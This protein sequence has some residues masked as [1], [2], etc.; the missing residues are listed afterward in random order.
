MK[1]KIKNIVISQTDRTNLSINIDFQNPMELEKIFDKILK[2]IRPPRQYGSGRTESANYEY[3]V[4]RYTTEAMTNGDTVFKY[5]S[6]I[7]V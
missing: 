4:D 1:S 7:N 2:E 6:K 3:S 5:K